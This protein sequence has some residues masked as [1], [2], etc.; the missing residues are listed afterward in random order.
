MYPLNKVGSV[1]VASLL[2]VMYMVSDSFA[3]CVALVRIH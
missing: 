3:L 1:L 2:C